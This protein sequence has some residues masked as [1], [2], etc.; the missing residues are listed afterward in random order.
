MNVS[1]KLGQQRQSLTLNLLIGQL[2]VECG[3]G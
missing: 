1:S 3:K 2:R